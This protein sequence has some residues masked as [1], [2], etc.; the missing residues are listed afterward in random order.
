MEEIKRKEREEKARE[1][2]EARERKI[3][4]EVEKKKVQQ[5]VASFN[6]RFMRVKNAFSRAGPNIVNT[7]RIADTNGDGTI[8][9]EEFM[10]AMQRV[11]VSI[12]AEELLYV[13]DFIDENRDGKIQY[14]ELTDVL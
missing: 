1:E 12:K 2:E 13:Y 10:T 6:Q 9:L 5:E 7:L 14:K 8:S 4:A 11:N 3:R